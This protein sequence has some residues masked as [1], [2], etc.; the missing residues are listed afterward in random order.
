MNIFKCTFFLI[1]SFV[2]TSV[3]AAPILKDDEILLSL[4]EVTHILSEEDIATVFVSNPDIVDYKVIN[5]KKVMI[6]G[7]KSGRTDV[8]I[9]IR[10]RA[11]RKYT[12]NIDPILANF[13]R[14]FVY[15][16]C[17]ECNLH[18]SSSYSGNGVTN[19]YLSGMLANNY[20]RDLAIETLSRL[21][22]GLNEKSEVI[23]NLIVIN[24]VSINVKLTVVE[25]SSVVSKTIGIEWASLGASSNG[26]FIVNGFDFSALE[27]MNVINALADNNLGKLVAKPNMTLKSGENASFLAG[28]EFPILTVNTNGEQVFEYKEF[29]VKL[30]V[31]ATL[32]SS[33]RVKLMISNEVSFIESTFKVS[34][35]TLPIFKTNRSST[36]INIGDNEMLIIGGMLYVSEASG[37]TGLPYLSDIPL[38]GKLFSSQKDLLDTRELLVIAE[39]DFVNS[40]KSDVS[41]NYEMDI[42]RFKRLGLGN[43]FFLLEE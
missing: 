16:K 36:V 5:T 8:I 39:V 24:E 14:D 31:A 3:F 33:N 26:Q 28:G 19:Y 41:L 27:I 1:I 9:Y 6:Y 34:G 11:E 21:V 12:I 17:S 38:V 20:E 10:G 25:I 13:N 15:N 42:K 40:H 32:T 29:G 7:K 35:S 23:D 18:L 4:G 30:D 22:K 2:F 43:D 37:E